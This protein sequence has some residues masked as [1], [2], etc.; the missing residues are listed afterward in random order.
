MVRLFNLNLTKIK[1][2]VSSDPEVLDYLNLLN[3]IF[4]ILLI[5]IGSL[6]LIFWS[7]IEITSDGL[8]RY[9]SIMKF[10]DSGVLTPMKY[11]YVGS[12]F[13]LPLYYLGVDLKYFNVTVFVL[14]LVFTSFVMKSFF[15]VDFIIKFILLMVIGSMFTGHT[16]DFFGETFSA[17]LLFLGLL[18][19]VLNKYKIASILL[20]SLSIANSSVLLIPLSLLIIFMVFKE[21]R[22]SYL[23]YLI[24]PVL[25]IFTENFLKFDHFINS[26]YS[27]DHGLKTMMPYSGLPDFSY[28]GTCQPV[29]HQF[30]K[31]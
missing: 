26:G 9:D 16:R 30:F 18:L 15:K 8:I 6:I 12:F 29:L 4:G 10:V 14:T 2:L 24:I 20:V 22:L 27:N 17:S 7:E 5:I 3:Y 13:S 23:F 11:S 21:K 1:H 25:M 19:L 31:N 28:P